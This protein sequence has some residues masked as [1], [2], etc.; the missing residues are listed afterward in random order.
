MR[1]SRSIE[2]DFEPIGRIRRPSNIRG[3]P[4]LNV[5]VPKES[6]PGE[7]RV[8]VTPDIAGRLVKCGLQ[9]TVETGAGNA[10][11]FL[12]DAYR[13]AG[14]AIAPDPGALYGGA[15][16]ILK[17]QRPNATEISSIRKGSALI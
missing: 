12:D 17:V 11:G 13:S 9:V 5:A 14:A 7:C 16:F 4:S 3:G 15:D 8:A 10:A 2:E 1:G 6:A